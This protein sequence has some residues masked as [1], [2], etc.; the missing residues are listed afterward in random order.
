MTFCI[1][2]RVVDVELHA[3][4]DLLDGVD[5]LVPVN[6]AELRVSCGC[7]NGRGGGNGW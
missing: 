1:C 4:M 2:S 3:L 5:R 7:S 6:I